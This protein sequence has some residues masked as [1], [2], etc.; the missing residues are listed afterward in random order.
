MATQ[1]IESARADIEATD[2]LLVRALKL[3]GLPAALF[4]RMRDM[5]L[6]GCNVPQL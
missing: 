5:A 6:P 3:S 2:D 1:E 4:R